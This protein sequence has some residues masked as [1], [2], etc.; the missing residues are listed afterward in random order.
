[1]GYLSRTL[2]R[3]GAEDGV[4]NG[5]FREEEAV[6]QGFFTFTPHFFPFLRSISGA[7]STLF[8]K[9]YAKLIYVT[10]IISI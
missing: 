6:F 8:K 1:M 5:L 9:F 7:K 2:T 3:F 10:R 4:E